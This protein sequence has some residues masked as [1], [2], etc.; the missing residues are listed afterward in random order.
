MACD[1]MLNAFEEFVSRK[2]TVE[3]SEDLARGN[4]ALKC[5]CF[6]T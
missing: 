2:Y 3:T 4:C 6:A 5:R 1:G